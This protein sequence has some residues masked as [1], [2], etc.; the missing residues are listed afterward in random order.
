MKRAACPSSKLDALVAA[1]DKVV[2]IAAKLTQQHT[3]GSADSDAVTAEELIPHIAYSIA[4]A[5]SENKTAHTIT[6]VLTP[7]LVL[8]SCHPVTRTQVV[9][10][11]LASLFAHLYVFRDARRSP[12][13]LPITSFDLHTISS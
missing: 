6:P 3:G 4:H 1:C 13:H 7:T 8:S 10:G 12:T 2:E 5:V 9:K 11:E